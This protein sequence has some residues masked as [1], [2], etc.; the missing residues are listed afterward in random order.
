M[1]D[2]KMVRRANLSLLVHEVGSVTALAKMVSTA[3]SYLS[4]IIG[5]RPV[6]SVGDELARRLEFVCKKPHGWMD[7]THETEQ[8]QAKCRAV[9]D[10]LMVLPEKKIDALI[11][12]FDL[13]A[14]AGELGRINLEAIP[15]RKT[16][17]RVVHLGKHHESTEP[18]K[19][20]SR[21]P[22]STR[23]IAG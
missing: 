7:V 1:M 6:R 17:P 5:P 15:K 10:V 3:Q 13:R 18:A 8:K 22:K 19:S 16:G 12:L 2:N 14:T 9:F 4:Q 11:E 20:K 23:T 21:K